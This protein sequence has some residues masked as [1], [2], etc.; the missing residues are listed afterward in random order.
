M[1]NNEHS[2]STDDYADLKYILP[3]IYNGNENVLGYDSAV[4]EYRTNLGRK[5]PQLKKTL[6]SPVPMKQIR[7]YPDVRPSLS[8]IIS[9]RKILGDVTWL[10]DYAVIGFAKCGTSSL[11]TWVEGNNSTFIFEKE[12]CS[13]SFDETPSRLVSKLYMD[14]PDD[15]EKLRGLKC[16]VSL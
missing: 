2:S 8:Q 11:K 12:Q 13:M 9:G 3:R 15:K 7:N 4:N 14:F 1:S 6:V 10:L 5:V 16:P